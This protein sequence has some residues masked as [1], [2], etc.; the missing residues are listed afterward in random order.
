MKFHF[1]TALLALCL[2]LQAC[3]P[4]DKKQDI[5]RIGF[6]DLLTDE[7]L[8]RARKGFFMALKDG[9]YEAEKNL[10]IIYRNAQGDQP[11]LT[12]ACSYMVAE[13][14][15][16]IASCPT[17]STL[18]AVKQTHSI[19]VF[20]MVTPRPDLAGMVDA[21]G[22]APANLCGVYETL[23]YIDTSIL[24][25]RDIL[26]GIQRL[27][28][29]YNQSEPQSAL[30]LERI[31]SR[32]R[33]SGIELIALPVTNTNETELVVA[34]VLNKKPDAFFALPDNVVFASME[35]I[36]RT[37]D[38]SQVPVFTSEE[39]L[40][41]RGAT[42]GFGADMYEWG[43]QCGRQAA[44]FLSGELK[45]PEPEP[46]RIRKKVYNPAKAQS[47]GLHPDSSFSAVQ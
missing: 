23:E 9:G 46:V 17:L 40:V 8:A 13:D 33:E 3:A 10:A 38:A 11:T 6:L 20:M 16:L 36:V 21:Q 25:I 4:K 39:G 28:A 41:R 47:F 45:S 34:A 14:V 29:V 2:G 26:P 1:R 32:C 22:K 37:C 5:P 30:A 15:D 7:T 12:Q 31:R 42:A 43:Y 24:L 19:P 35:L 44:R 27:G 18:A